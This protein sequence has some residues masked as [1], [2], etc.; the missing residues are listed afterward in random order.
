MLPR[1]DFPDAL[2]Y[3]S[4]IFQMLN[5]SI[6]LSVIQD[7][8]LSNRGKKQGESNAIRPRKNLIIIY[9][10]PGSGKTTIAEAIAAAFRAHVCDWDDCIPPAI[11]KKIRKKTLPTEE[12][13]DALIGQYIGRIAE[14]LTAYPV[15]A[16][17]SLPF[18]RH[19][20]QIRQHFPGVLFLYL[21]APFAVLQQ[22]LSRRQRHFFNPALLE[23]LWHLQ[24]PPDADH[25]CID[26]GQDKE[27]VVREAKRIV[28]SAGW[29]DLQL[30]G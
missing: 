30:F 10:L 20:Q 5:T 14:M 16:S 29:N 9:G 24:E 2:Q 13:R 18:R 22:R 11:K 27:K 4:F 19:R 8:H 7:P 25:I 17:C 21:D 15:V 1:H 12:E 26:A 3:R 6:L 23:K 28:G